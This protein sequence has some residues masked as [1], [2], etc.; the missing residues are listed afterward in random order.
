MC[1]II[2]I[3]LLFIRNISN[4]LYPLRYIQ[5]RVLPL[6]LNSKY[7]YWDINRRYCINHHELLVINE[8]LSYFENLI[9]ICIQSR[10][11]K[12][13]IVSCRYVLLKGHPLLLLLVV[14]SSLLGVVEE[15]VLASFWDFG[16]SVLVILKVLFDHH[17]FLV[18]EVF[19]DFVP[20]FCTSF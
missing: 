8:R 6:S 12:L 4:I 16:L 17:K 14:F 20:F 13:H 7:R 18:F 1:H 19:G 15:S 11:T 3:V 2:C 5:L 10:L 9:S